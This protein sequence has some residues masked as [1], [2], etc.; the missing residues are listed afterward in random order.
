MHVDRKIPA[1]GD[2]CQRISRNME[3]KRK[4]GRKKRREKQ[5]RRKKNRWPERKDDKKAVSAEKE[6]IRLQNKEES[7]TMWC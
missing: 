2:L 4:D 7:L 5:G 3:R 1:D 6:K